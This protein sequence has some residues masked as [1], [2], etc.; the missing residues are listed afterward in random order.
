M[1]ANPAPERRIAR[2][3][4]RQLHAM[5][6]AGILAE[7]EPVELID[8]VLVLV[9]KLLAHLDGDLAALG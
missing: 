1:A 9:V 3:D 5:L 2:L 4:V 7:G 8:G 6:E